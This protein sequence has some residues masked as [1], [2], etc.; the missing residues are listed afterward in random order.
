MNRCSLLTCSNPV[1]APPCVVSTPPLSLWTQ[2]HNRPAPY[3]RVPACPV[4][5][6]QVVVLSPD[7]EEPLEAVDTAHVYVV[8]GIVDR[9]VRKGLTVKFAVGAALAAGLVGRG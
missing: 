4:G 8:G 5:A 9:T 2:P 7:A 1:P 3:V 6:Q